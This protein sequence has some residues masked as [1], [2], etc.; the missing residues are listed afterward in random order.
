MGSFTTRGRAEVEHRILSCKQTEC[1]DVSFNQ[2]TQCA[3]VVICG[4]NCTHW[5]VVLSEM[6]D[7]FHLRVSLMV[8]NDKLSTDLL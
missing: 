4:I 6:Y 1:C 5:V 2:S 3:A 7:T 8:N